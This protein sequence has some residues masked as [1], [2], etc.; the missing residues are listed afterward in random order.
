MMGDFLLGLILSA[1][2]PLDGFKLYWGD[3]HSQSGLCDGT[4]SPKDLY[5]YARTAAG[6]DFASV[7]SHDFE[8][9][10]REWDEIKKATKDANKPEEF[11]TFL[12]YEWSG[13]S[14][15]GGDNNINF[16]G[17]DGPLLYNGP[18]GAYP[19]WDPGEGEV[20]VMRN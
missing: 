16:L 7:S 19:A 4:N 15:R 10:A 8:L 17:D 2:S 12:G 6:L 5:E 14:D 3:L 13:G 18:Y 9:P 20:T 1:Q 11:V